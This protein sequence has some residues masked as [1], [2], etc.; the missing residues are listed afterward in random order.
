MSIKQGTHLKAHPG[1]RR[2]WELYVEQKL[3]FRALAARLGIGQ[4]TARAWLKAARIPS[5]TVSEGKRGQ[6]PAPQTVLASVI[7]RRKHAISGRPDVGYKVDGYGYV[8]VWVAAEQRYVAE[9]RMVMEQHLGRPLH[10]SEDV[11]HINGAKTDNRIENLELITRAAHLKE[12]YSS[13]K[14]DSRGRFMAVKL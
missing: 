1:A 5:R 13:R 14:L 2:L 6:R 10:P 3:S 4:T 12:H 8:K 7:S 9:H 11:H